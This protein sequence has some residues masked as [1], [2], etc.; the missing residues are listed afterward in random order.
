LALLLAVLQGEDRPD[1]RTRV[2]TTWT[3][4]RS[5]VAA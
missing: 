5:C 3:R 1:R 2:C 4:W